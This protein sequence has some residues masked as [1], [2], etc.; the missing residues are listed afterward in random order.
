MKGILIDSNR[1]PIIT[2]G[3]ML[4]GDTDNQIVECVLATSRGEWKEV[5]LIG[6]NA[7]GM[8]GGDPDVMWASDT[9][10]QL[11][12]CGVHIENIT[13]TNGIITII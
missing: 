13:V 9:R 6:A 7:I 10:K 1:D 5:P 8:L 11:E 12:A 2:N 4:I 3:S